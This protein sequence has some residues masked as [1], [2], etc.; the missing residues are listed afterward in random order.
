MRF[1]F[2]SRRGQFRF[3][4]VIDETNFGVGIARIEEVSFG[5]LPDRKRYI[6]VYFPSGGDKFWLIPQ[7]EEI[8]F[9]LFS[10]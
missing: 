3:I 7:V 6:V 5:L 8:N 9:G 10:K 4:V 1:I 2:P